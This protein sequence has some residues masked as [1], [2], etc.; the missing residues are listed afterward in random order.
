[1]A[2]LG[3]QWQRL[4]DLL[5]ARRIE[6]SRTIDPDWRFRRRFADQHQLDYR[7]V[8]DLETGRRNNYETLTFRRIERAYRWEVGS[9]DQVLIGGD[10]GPLRDVPVS[11]IPEM[12]GAE[13]ALEE[14]RIGEFTVHLGKLVEVASEMP[15][16]ELEEARRRTLE[17]LRRVFGDLDK[18]D[19][20]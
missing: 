8:S 6:L 1:M 13:L 15:S 5:V 9:I 10:P 7:T 3:Q 18:G 2:Q 14:V 12:Q 20:L 16:E 19:F 17:T 11:P 4:G